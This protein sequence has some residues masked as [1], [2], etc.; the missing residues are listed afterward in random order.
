MKIPSGKNIIEANE[1]ICDPFPYWHCHQQS[2][3]VMTPWLHHPMPSLAR[4]L[5]L[6]LALSLALGHLS[7]HS[8]LPNFHPMKQL[9]S[10]V[11]YLLPESS[12]KKNQ[13]R[14]TGNL[15]LQS[16]SNCCF[17]ATKFSWKQ[18]ET[19]RIQ[20]VNRSKTRSCSCYPAFCNWSGEQRFWRGNSLKLGAY[21]ME[22]IW[23]PSPAVVT[24]G[25]PCLLQVCFSLLKLFFMPPCGF[26]KFFGYGLDHLLRSMNSF[27][28]FPGIVSICLDTCII[29][30]H[31]LRY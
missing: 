16:S 6:N 9:G 13:P 17:S 8:L 28:S 22:T 20:H 11:L 14:S 1:P 21:H 19:G 15:H 12:P 29:M 2:Q 18:D 24:H 10:F 23:K 7:R 5:Q 4:A 25:G 27:D 26:Q 3:S 31:I 30:S